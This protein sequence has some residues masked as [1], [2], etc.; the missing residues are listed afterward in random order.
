MKIVVTL[1]VEAIGTTAVVTERFLWFFIRISNWICCD[2]TPVKGG[3]W[4]NQ[5]TAEFASRTLNSKLSTA[6]RATVAILEAVKTNELS[7][8]RHGVTKLKLVTPKQDN[9]T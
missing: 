2:A 4:V 1:G 3:I 7:S 8:L 9:Q 6:A 5:D